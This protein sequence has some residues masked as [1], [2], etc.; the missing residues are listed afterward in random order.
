MRK[1]L[2]IDQAQLENAAN[3][4]VAAEN[5][6]SDK[7]L[8]T[9]SRIISSSR[10]SWTVPNLK[11]NFDLEHETKRAL[12]EARHYMNDVLNYDDLY[13]EVEW[14]SKDDV[15][16]HVKD[17]NTGNLVNSYAGTDMLKLYSQNKKERG[18]IVD[19]RV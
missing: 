7:A 1:P 13:V 6:K 5:Q 17:K 18:I 19:G 11:D 10:E 12:S 14:L 8:G 9:A 4:K 16:G 2:A 15:H 3:N